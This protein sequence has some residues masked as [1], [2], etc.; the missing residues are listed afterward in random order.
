MEILVSL[1]LEILT[2]HE[3][4]GVVGSEDIAFM[5]Q[6]FGEIWLGIGSSLYS[7]HIARSKCLIVGITDEIECTVGIWVE[8]VGII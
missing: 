8:G 6:A 2:E 3:P 7:G 5:H 4:S 1:R